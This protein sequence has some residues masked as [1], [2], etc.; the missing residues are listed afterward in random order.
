MKQTKKGFTLV[1]LLVV[2]AILAIL[3]TVSIV[4]YTSFI[5]KAN[6]SN[7]QATISMINRNLQAEWLTE[8]PASAAEAY[9]S[10][11]SLGFTSEKLIP[12][13]GGFHYVYDLNAN[14]MYLFDKNDNLIYPENATATGADLWTQFRER[15]D[16]VVDGVTNYVAMQ[17]VTENSA[18]FELVFASGSYKLDLNGYYL[19]RQI[20]DGVTITVINGA[21]T[22]GTGFTPGEGA[23]E[24]TVAEN[25]ANNVANV[26]IENK[27]ID[28]ATISGIARHQGS[29]TIKNCLI[30]GDSTSNTF[31]V[32]GKSVT[33]EGCTFTG[34]GKWSLSIDSAKYEGSTIV[35]KNNTFINTARGI[36]FGIGYDNATFEGNTF[37]LGKDAKSNAIQLFISASDTALVKDSTDVKASSVVIK[38]NK[39]ETCNAAVILHNGL[40]KNLNIDADDQ[41]KTVEEW[42]NAI[43]NAVTFEN[44]TFGELGSGEKVIADPDQSE[45][46]GEGQVELMAWYLEQFQ[47]KVR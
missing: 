6:L 40:V 10:L 8:K 7:D 14:Q 46:T 32:A 29:V 45:L 28:R 30:V 34:F 13:S 2:I 22:P 1:E 47:Q 41:L 39:F 16:D 23:T 25:P 35:V 9:A 27:I 26:T 12:Y 4:G 3:A 15:A 24:L 44:N 33:I 42:R 43:V 5:E 19:D 17:P 18:N 20:H 11:Y 38:N 36:S 21:I 37:N 31:T